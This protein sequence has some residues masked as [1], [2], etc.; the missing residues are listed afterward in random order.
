MKMLLSR[1]IL[2]IT[3]IN[4]SALAV[5]NGPKYSNEE[6]LKLEI[7]G[8]SLS[9]SYQDIKRKMSSNCMGNIEEYTNRLK[10]QVVY[11][12]TLSC[13]DKNEERTIDIEA[14]FDHNKN[15]YSIFR[16]INFSSKPDPEILLHKAIKKYGP[17]TKGLNSTS[18][19]FPV[20]SSKL[21]WSEFYPYIK[22][23]SFFDHTSRPSIKSQHKGAELYLSLY[24]HTCSNTYYILFTE[25]TNYTIKN[26]SLLWIENENKK[27]KTNMTSNVEF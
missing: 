23:P 19:C 6:I 17:Y 21:F 1:W 5:P 24:F 12:Y 9:D 14:E 27:Y 13:S 8:I 7:V 20:I 11:R 18:E 3:I 22:T 26:E 10:S 15:L 2:L 25:L 4:I 16:K